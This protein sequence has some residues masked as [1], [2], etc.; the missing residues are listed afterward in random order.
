M[1][2]KNDNGLSAYVPPPPSHPFEVGERYLTLSGVLVEIIS[3]HGPPEC[4][5][6]LGSDGIHRYNRTQDR[7]RVTGSSFD[8]STEPLNLV[9]RY[10]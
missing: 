4:A 2:G 6:A 10:L 9:P 1:I 5:T 8:L 3:V 7:G